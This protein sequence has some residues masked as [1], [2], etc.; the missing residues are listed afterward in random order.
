MKHQSSITS[1]IVVHD[2]LLLTA[3]RLDAPALVWIP[4]GTTL[5]PLAVQH[6]FFTIHY[7]QHC[8]FFPV[9][10]CT[11]WAD[12]ASTSLRFTY[13]LRVHAQSWPE[14]FTTALMLIPAGVPIARLGQDQ[15]GILI[16]QGDGRQGF[17]AG[18]ANWNTPPPGCI[19]AL[20]WYLLGVGWLTVNWIGMLYLIT[21]VLGSLPRWGVL[22][23]ALVGIVVPIIFLARARS[24]FTLFFS[25]GALTI[26]VIGGAIGIAMAPR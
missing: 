2:S 16:Q 21:A 13:P 11:P 5:Q 12:P 26:G 8:G 20:G 4:A 6:G 24:D 3:P 10:V 7:H 25:I 23:P 19:T 9:A 22:L 18:H 17:I 1:T 15:T 14:T